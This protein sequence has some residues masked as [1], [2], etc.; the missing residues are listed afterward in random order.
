MKLHA[1][2]C[3][4]DESPTWLA[5][6]VASLSRIGVDH[7]IAVD[8]RYPHFKMGAPTNSRIDEVDAITS[9]AIGCGMAVTMHRL[10]EP[11]TEAQKRSIAFG[12]LNATAK[13]D[14]WVLVIDADEMVIDGDESLK[15][16]LSELDASI[17]TA[18]CFVANA[19]DPYA[20]PETDND[21]SEKT[22][23]LHQKFPITSEFVS[24]Q[25][26]LWRVMRDMRVEGTHSS[27]TGVDRDGARWN[28]RPDIGGANLKGMP[29]TDIA[30]L[31]S[32]LTIQ[33][34]KN[35]RTVERR[36]LKKAYYDLRDELGIERVAT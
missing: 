30:R 32:S 12:L 34:R 1:I 10:L 9:T 24:A 27:Y 11:V 22:L 13:L 28:L 26:R 29:R 25:S 8:G 20:R 16:E 2:L 18:S 5:G 31:D 4:Y 15:T 23:E 36:E 19:L 6:C 7:V 17:F 3:W 35:H 21:V 33:H 14:D